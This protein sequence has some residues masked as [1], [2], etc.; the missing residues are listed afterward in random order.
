MKLIA[1]K[2][3]PRNGFINDNNDNVVFNKNITKDPKKAVKLITR[4]LAPRNGFINGNYDNVIY[5]EKYI[6]ERQKQHGYNLYN[7]TA[8]VNQT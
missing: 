8:Y 1:R 3:A 5:E 2:F 7:K 6:K 4:K